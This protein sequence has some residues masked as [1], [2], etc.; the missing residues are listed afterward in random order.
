MTDQLEQPT[1]TA[2]PVFG[3]WTYYPLAFGVLGFIVAF[4]VAAIP[5][6]HTSTA[7][8]DIVNFPSMFGQYVVALL[9]A[10]LSSTLLLIGALGRLLRPRP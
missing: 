8:G 3:G 2:H 4:V 5:P 1:H 10:V 9:I 6:A 7:G